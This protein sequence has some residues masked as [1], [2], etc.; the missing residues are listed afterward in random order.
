MKR[1]IIS[2]SRLL[3]GVLALCFLSLLSSCSKTS[4]LQCKTCGGDGKVKVWF[5]CPDCGGKGFT[6]ISESGWPKIHILGPIVIFLTLVLISGV[7]EWIKEKNNGQSPEEGKRA[8]ALNH[9]RDDTSSV[10]IIGPEGSG[11]TVFLE[12]LSRFAD[13]RSDEL[14]FEP[15]DLHSSQYV[16]NARQL[17]ERGN[18]P[19]SNP[20][21]DLKTLKWQIGELDDELHDLILFDY[22]GQDMRSVLLEEDPDKLQGR[23]RELREEIDHSDLLI[24]LLDIDGLIGSGSLLETN[25]NFWLLKTFLTR[26]D[27][28]E[29]PKIVVVTKA[30][31][32]A[33]MFEESGGDLKKSIGSLLSGNQGGNALRRHLKD[34]DCYSL[35][36]ILTRTK[37][38]DDS[39]PV[40]VPRIPLQS[41]GFDSLIE[42]ILSVLDE[43]RK[44]GG[45]FS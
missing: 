19:K 1:R 33:E 13:S 14:V 18:W 8:I 20:Q 45:W 32:Y 12:A 6:I 16:A 10:F 40:R 35:T 42:G 22:S 41:E 11:K 23:T 29:K 17:L 26:P 44:E 36:S 7:I 31:L 28:A 38:A 4:T 43:T 21:G 25:E 2:C 34:V 3:L 5:E 9:N 39:L 24:Y 27:W 15:S 30:E 37:V